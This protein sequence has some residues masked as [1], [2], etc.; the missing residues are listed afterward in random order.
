MET[1]LLGSKCDELR[2]RLGDRV[3][4]GPLEMIENMADVTG[5]KLDNDD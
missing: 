1:G 4:F 5:C 2:F 3:D